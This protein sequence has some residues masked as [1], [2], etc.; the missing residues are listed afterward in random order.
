MRL[1]SLTLT[2]NVSTE[3]KRKKTN[4]WLKSR[5]LESTPPHYIKSQQEL[6]QEIQLEKL[7]ASFDEDRSGTLD[8]KELHDMFK[9]NNVKVSLGEVWRLIKTVDE[10]G[11]GQLSIVEF[12]RFLQ[13]EKA[14]ESKRRRF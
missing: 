13:S 14:S 11:S 1:P 9:A 3:L 10:D 6:Q 8:V 4:T 12:K 2:R 7:F 5:H